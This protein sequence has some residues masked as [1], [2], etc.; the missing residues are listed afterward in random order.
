MYTSRMF[1]KKGL[2]TVLASFV[3]VALVLSV[4][5]SATAAPGITA[6]IP[7]GGGTASVAIS[8]DES[9]VYISRYF[10]KEIKVVDVAT[11]T[12]TDSLSFP[13]L[14]GVVWSLAM[15]PDGNT[16]Y[17]IEYSNGP[18]NNLLKIDLTQSPASIVS[19]VA[20]GRQVESMAITPDGTKVYAASQPDSTVVIVDTATMS[21]T[22]TIGPFPSSISGQNLMNPQYV[23][24]SPTGDYAY[25]SFAKRGGSSGVSGVV[26][27]RTTDNTAVA[28]ITYS[29]SG[30]DLSVN[31]Q[32]MAISADGNSLYVSN[33]KSNGGWIRKHNVA[34]A[35]LVSTP[36][37]E[38]PR[39][40]SAIF[41]SAVAVSHANDTL[42]GSFDNRIYFFSTVDGS[43]LGSVTGVSDSKSIQ[44]SKTPGSGWAYAASNSS[45]A[46]QI[47]IALSPG[48]QE[49]STDGSSSLSSTVFSPVGF[50]GTPTYSISGTLPAGLSFNNA[51]GV[52]TGIATAALAAT[53][54]TITASDGTYSTTAKI[55]LTSTVPVPVPATA[56]PATATPAST[57]PA[58]TLAR[59]GANIEWLMVAGLLVSIA[60]SGFLA[61][62]RRKRQA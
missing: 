18:Q 49:L 40:N 36:V 54:F 16:L 5:L 47:G 7:M 55:R 22:A 45:D 19:S 24:V 34:G 11:N 56:R 14:T 62:S 44:A 39:P 20:V 59:T 13:S 46:S 37:F 10:T 15:S 42:Y 50:S 25:V 61:F 8:P 9:T 6:T 31:A 17:A 29:S 23:V 48:W 38:I 35:D 52:I 60:G 21:V 30:T 27:I 41:A 2:S 28:S 53:T 1:I 4:P 57:A 12:V 43:T 58:S 51:N 33:N 32:Y 26:K 3:S